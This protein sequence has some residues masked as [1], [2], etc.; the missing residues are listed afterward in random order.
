MARAYTPEQLQLHLIDPKTTELVSFEDDPHVMGEIGGFAEDAIEILEEAVEEMQRRYKL[1]KE[2]KAKDISAYKT[3]E[4]ELD[5]EDLPWR[6]LV[7]DE[8][9][10][11]TSDNEDRKTIEKSLRRLAQKAWVCGIHVIVATQKIS[12]I[13]ISTTIRSNLPVQLA[14]RVNSATDSRIVMDEGEAEALGGKRRCISKM[15]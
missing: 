2:H 9:A 14:L 13:I 5:R 6:V 15:H 4:V 1:L 12:A 10:D 11:L 8:Y 3:A 7:L